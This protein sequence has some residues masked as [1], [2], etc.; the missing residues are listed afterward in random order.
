MPSLCD[1][2]RL[3]QISDCSHPVDT[4][5]VWVTVAVMYVIITVANVQRYVGGGNREDDDAGDGRDA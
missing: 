4:G 3:S 2:G 5:A 1:A